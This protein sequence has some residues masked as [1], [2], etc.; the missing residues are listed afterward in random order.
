M[1]EFDFWQQKIIQF[2]HDPVAKPFSGLRKGESQSKIGK[3]LFDAFQKLK[4]GRKLRHWYKSADW[5]A[6]GADRPMLYVPRKK[7]V[8]GLGVVR[9]PNEPVITHPLSPGFQLHLT[10]EAGLPE[11]ENP[12]EDGE[13]DRTLVGEGPPD[14]PRDPIEEARVMANLL[15]DLVPDWKSPQYL[16][17]GFI[18]LWRRFRD[19]LVA[20]YPHNPL[21]EEL[22]SDSRS[23]DH[24][25]WDHL[26]VTTALAFMKPHK[27][28]EAP[29]DEGA[30]QPW[31]LRVSLGPVQDF[32]EQSRTSRDLW[33]SSFLLAD[34]SWQAMRPIVERYGPDCIVY[35]DLNANPRA[36]CW[37]AEHHAD[38]LREEARHPSTFAAVLP[39]AFV[40][41][42]PRGGPRGGDGHLLALEDLAERARSS[43]EERWRE[44]A[45]AVRDWFA[46]KIAPGKA[47]EA[48]WRRQHE[49]CPI[50]VTWTAVPW[51]P[52][53]RIK[54]ESSLR[55]RALP[56]QRKEG[57]ERDPEDDQAIQARRDRLAPWVPPAT[58]AHYEFARDVFAHSYLK[59]HQMERGFDYALTH[60][61]LRVRHALREEAGW[62]IRDAGEP[63]EKCTLCGLREAL[64]D[65]GEKGERIGELRRQAR[66][67]WKHEK[68]DP[69]RTGSERLCAVCA[70]KRFLIEADRDAEVFNHLWIGIG[71]DPKGMRDRD[72]RLRMPFPAAATIAAQ[73]FI[74]K[75]I[76]DPDCASE[77]DAVV[78]ACRSARL[79]CTSFPRSLPRL[80]ALVSEVSDTAKTFLEFEA[81]DTLFPEVLLGKARGLDPD[82]EEGA[83]SLRK[84]KTAVKDLRD[85]ATASGHGAPATRVAAIRLDGDRMGQ[86]LLG[87]E[88][89][90]A[91]RWRDVLHPEARRRLRDPERAKHLKDAGWL[92][93]L[94]SRRLMGPSLH[95]FVSRTLGHFSH[96]IVPWVVEREFS[97]RLIYAGGDD[98]L[99]LAPA[100][101]AID[102][103]ARLQ[104]LFSA[105]WVVDTRP[106][107]DPW[108]WRRQGWSGSYDP[109]E[110]RRRFVI[111]LPDR[112]REGEPKPIELGVDGQ[113][114]AAHAADCGEPE[115]M[116]VRGN[117]LPM[118]GDGASLSAGI[119]IGHYKTPLSV[120][121]QRAREVLKTAK[122]QGRRGLGLGHASRGG[123]K[124]AFSIP[125]NDRSSGSDKAAQVILKTAIDGFGAGG[126]LPGRLPYKLRQLALSVRC[127]LREIDDSADSTSSPKERDERRS[128]FLRGLFTASLDGADAREAGRAAFALWRRGIDIHGVEDVEAEGR[129][130]DG[131]L[132]CRELARGGGSREGVE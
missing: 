87:D 44:L 96:R 80:A 66:G 42:V 47:W 35:P 4:E 121:L 123:A 132:F 112:D 72:D 16:R 120:Q 75:V 92:S 117:L 102:L 86:L 38:A 62:T 116:E 103:A 53:E 69:D 73:V 113:R 48:I 8:S 22:P 129:Y 55:G 5:A 82:D 110:A 37:L 40:A 79:P 32:I 9:W 31:M 76:T 101:E 13:D 33:V 58:W 126:G 124:T 2:F 77:L 11:K 28:D 43:V 125:W 84:L 3:E 64:H 34:L 50:H 85:K 59:F 104:Q 51:H 114:I 15:A 56:A 10:G 70:V 93:L 71:I 122:D 63:G 26:K 18:S 107:S 111:P 54:S 39:E 105:A 7:G 65:G 52:L 46:D 19:E 1:D 131:L 89:A 90:I 100:D 95:A 49:R 98:I 45:G 118:L 119:A 109:E 41:L 60:H 94:D 17:K 25:I 67:F 81:Q 27:M 115:D 20:S 127:G 74:Q 29:G 78:R 99:C 97:G 130:T 108:D 91:T 24:A 21:W 23:P 106:P 36:D 68:L 6:A 61:Q 30:R 57:R 12:L 88:Q 128:E 14:E 83:K